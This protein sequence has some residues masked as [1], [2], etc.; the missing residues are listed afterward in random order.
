MNSKPSIGEQKKRY[1]SDR[2]DPC[3][4]NCHVFFIED[5]RCIRAKNLIRG[6]VI[7]KLGGLF[8]VKYRAERWIAYANY[9]LAENITSGAGKDHTN[10]FGTKSQEIVEYMGFYNFKIVGNRP[11]AEVPEKFRIH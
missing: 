3:Q 2:F 6:D 7:R 10:L 5:K 1:P 8:M 11:F 4:N 9:S